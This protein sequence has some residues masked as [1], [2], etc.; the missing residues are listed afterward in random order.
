MLFPVAIKAQQ[1][2][3]NL[4]G[5]AS[6]QAGQQFD[7][8]DW[9]FA[10]GGE[11]FFYLNRHILFGAHVLYNKWTPDEHSFTEQIRSF[12]NTDITGGAFSLEM[13]PVLRVTTRYQSAINIFLQAGAGL[14]IINN[15][16]TI[17][18]TSFDATFEETFGAGTRGRFG[19]SLAAGFTL[20]D[21]NSLSIDLFPAFNMVFLNE[22]DAAFQYF[23]LNLGIALN[24]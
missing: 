17:E 4:I 18:A 1:L 2:K 9:G 23:T 15:Q 10:A 16:I 24:I 8:F 11:L 6:R 3:I 20:G 5:S 19:I 7:N 22:G 14:Y 21:L 12:F 13:L